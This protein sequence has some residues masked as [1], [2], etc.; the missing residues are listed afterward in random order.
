MPSG[1][2]APLPC[3]LLSPT[4]T[5]SSGPSIAMQFCVRQLLAFLDKYDQVP[6]MVIK[7][8]TG[9]INYGG[10]VT[11]DWD[12]RTLMTLLDMFITPETMEDYY[13]FSPSG[14]GPASLCQ[15]CPGAA[16]VTRGAWGG[17]GFVGPV[18]WQRRGRGH[19]PPFVQAPGFVSKEL[20]PKGA[21]GSGWVPQRGRLFKFDFPSAKF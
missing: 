16:G 11:D 5:P 3:A 9:Q 12:R 2:P 10:R 4:P 20:T 17:A 14:A 21:G 1:A 6:Y 13:K 18:S 15:T 7:F 19:P 8:L